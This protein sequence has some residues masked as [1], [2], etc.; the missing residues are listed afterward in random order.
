MCIPDDNL[1]IKWRYISLKPLKHDQVTKTEKFMTEL[2]DKFQEI[3]GN[4]TTNAKNAQST[5]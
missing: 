1:V 5:V 2:A 4:M 3:H